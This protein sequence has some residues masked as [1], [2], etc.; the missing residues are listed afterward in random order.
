LRRLRI[1]SRWIAVTVCKNRG[2]GRQCQID[3]GC[4]GWDVPYRFCGCGLNGGTSRLHVNL[5][6]TPGTPRSCGGRDGRASLVFRVSGRV[7]PFPSGPRY[8]NLSSCGPRFYFTRRPIPS[9]VRAAAPG[10]DAFLV[11]SGIQV[12][13]S[14]GGEVISTRVGAA[15][16]HVTAPCQLGVGHET[17]VA[18]KRVRQC[19][20]DSSCA[21]DV[22]FLS[23]LTVHAPVFV[24][25]VPA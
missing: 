10:C 9:R 20:I 1:R 22:W 19:Q 3:I 17:W 21:G 8:R 13:L 23:R 7:R 15:W 5:A 16:D 11:T 25:F 6:L 2:S 12:K 14:G 4:A 18:A 24:T